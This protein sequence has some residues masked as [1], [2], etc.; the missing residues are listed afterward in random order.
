MQ[1]AMPKR[2]STLTLSFL[3]LL[4]ENLSAA[5]PPIT[6]LTFSPD[7]KSLVAGSQKGVELYRWPNLKKASS[8]ETQLHNVHDV[9]FSQNGELLAI[10]GGVPGEEGIVEVIQWPS[11][12]PL[13]QVSCNLDSVYSVKFSPDDSHI[14]AASLD[15]SG[16]IISVAERDV[17]RYLED[18]S[19]GLT[20]VAYLPDG[21]TIVT[22]GIDQSIRV[23]DETNSKP[24][25]NMDNHTMRVQ[26]IATRPTSEGLPVLVSTSTD[27]TVRFW[28]PT[29]G[30]MVRFKKLTCTPLAV[31]WLPGG[32]QV[33]VACDDGR[34]RV[35]D[36]VS[37]KNLAA[38]GSCQGM[39]I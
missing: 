14:A 35:I 9:A 27:R 11:L 16:A 32:E 3:I 12:K 18:H 1:K 19:R 4:G 25:R 2:L 22:S 37:L 28:Q 10:A 34:L 30:R 23:W 33:A 29:I 8:L 36:Y 39:G 7:G 20:S 17:V 31:E 26:A 21:K 13:F 5:E 38:V 15:H 6:T 24:I